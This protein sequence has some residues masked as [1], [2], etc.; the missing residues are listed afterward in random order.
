MYTA[1]SLVPDANP[2][3][4]TVH[5]NWILN[6]NLKKYRKISLVSNITV[7]DNAY[8]IS[9]IGIWKDPRRE[10]LGPD[11][12]RKMGVGEQIITDSSSFI[13]HLNGNKS[14]ITDIHNMFK[15][16]IVNRGKCTYTL[17]N[18][19]IATGI[20]HIDGIESITVVPADPPRQ[21]N[22]GITIRFKKP[23]IIMPDVI[24]ECKGATINNSMPRAMIAGF[25]M[26]FPQ[27][28]SFMEHEL[29]DFW[30]TQAGIKE[31]QVIIRQLDDK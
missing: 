12:Y 7:Y 8:Q 30:A 21:P 20:I 14:N 6:V 24:Q 19:A 23:K 28:I 15:D 3:A 27:T 16:S 18:E 2:V 31:Y 13:L 29:K 17:M 25:N 10:A 9:V 26:G 5:L 1:P 11:Y 22:R 4:V